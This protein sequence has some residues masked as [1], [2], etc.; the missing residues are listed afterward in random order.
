M[1]LHERQN[2]EDELSFCQ[3]PLHEIKEETT[4]GTFSIEVTKLICT[5]EIVVKIQHEDLSTPGKIIDLVKIVWQHVLTLAF[6]DVDADC[7]LLPVCFNLTNLTKC[8]L[9][10]STSVALLTKMLSCP[11]S[12]AFVCDFL[13]D[14]G[15]MPCK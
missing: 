10:A 12:V 8:H 11:L 13:L 7:L 6:F 1:E 3:H 9:L 5:L 15:R 14:R 4:K 2:A